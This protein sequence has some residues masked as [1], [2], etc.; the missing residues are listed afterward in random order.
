[1]SKMAR[2]INLA[3][4]P[5]CLAGCGSRVEGN[6]FYIPEKGYIHE[7]CLQIYCMD[8]GIDIDGASEGKGFE[9]VKI[10]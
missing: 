8:N 4:K 5:P 6:A 3:E 7:W 2:K 9:P 1:M 10:E